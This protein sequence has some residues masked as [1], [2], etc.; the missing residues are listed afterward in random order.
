MPI[1]SKDEF[2]D[3]IKKQVGDDASPEAVSFLEDMTD[4]YN[5]LSQ[6]AK[7]DGVDW[8][9]KFHDNDRAWAERYRSRFFSG[10]SGNIPSGPRG[11]SSGNGYRP[12]D[13]DFDDLFK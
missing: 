3:R 13:I 4:T 6:K 11:S 1:L 7:G 10:E 9:K 12:E 5:G 8:E 2:F